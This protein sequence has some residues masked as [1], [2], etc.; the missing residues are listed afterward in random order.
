MTGMTRTILV[1]AALAAACGGMSGPAA[2]SDL[3]AEPLSGGAHLTWKDNSTNEA[4]FMIERK[5]G[6]GSFATVGTV[7]F[8]TT[9]YHDAPVTSGTT[10]VY[11]VMA[12]GSAGHASGVP[13]NEVTF[14]AP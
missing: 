10:Y 14:N 9:Q 11:R 3:K 1:L 4:Q 5:T 7:P 12:V 8:D 2:P 13:S 6:T